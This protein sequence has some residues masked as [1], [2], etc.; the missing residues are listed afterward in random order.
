MTTNFKL[1][2]FSSCFKYPWYTPDRK[3]GVPKNRSRRID[4]KK[5]FGPTGRKLLIIESI[6]SYFV[7]IRNEAGEFV[8]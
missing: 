6:P 2:D 5:T 3:L 7:I 8:F 1:G 4:E